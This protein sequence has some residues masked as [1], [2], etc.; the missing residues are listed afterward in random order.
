MVRLCLKSS[1]DFGQDRRFTQV[2][3]HHTR[4]VH[5]MREHGFCAQ[6]QVPPARIRQSVIDVSFS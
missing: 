2:P 3:G 4:G 6:R 1:T 5:A